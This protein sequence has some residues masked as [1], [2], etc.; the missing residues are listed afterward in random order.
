VAMQYKVGNVNAGTFVAH[1]Y[2]RVLGGYTVDEAVFEGRLALF[3]QAGLEDRDWGVPV[4]YLRAEDGFLF[5]VPPAE[6]AADEAP[7]V[8]VQRELGTVRG[9]DIGARVGE[10]ISGRLEVRDRIDIVERGGSTTG[11]HID[12]LGGR[13]PGNPI[14]PD[15]D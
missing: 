12:R 11:V 10:V 4:L 3:N 1:L 9:D 2:T 8:L 5:P 14:G 13:P 15:A 6:A 7:V